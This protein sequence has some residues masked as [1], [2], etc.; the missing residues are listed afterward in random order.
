QLVE[1]EPAAAEAELQLVEPES[2]AAE[3]QPQPAEPEPPP[4]AIIMQE[5]LASY[6]RMEARPIPPPDEGTAVIFTPRPE[7]PAPAEMAA[8]EV[9]PAAVEAPRA[10][11]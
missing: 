2:D 6:E 10:I 3:A 7:P 5:L 4:S 1:P 8:V 11:V 9:A